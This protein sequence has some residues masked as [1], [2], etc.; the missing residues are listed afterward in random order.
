MTRIFSEFLG[1][2]SP[3]IFKENSE[4]TPV[5]VRCDCSH[6]PQ[7]FSLSDGAEAANASPL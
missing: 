6:K 4:K 5:I 2:L 3:Y 1:I 7:D